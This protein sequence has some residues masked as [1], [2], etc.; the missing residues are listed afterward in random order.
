MTTE[1]GI[2]VATGVAANLYASND[3]G[4]VNF[5]EQIYSTVKGLVQDTVRIGLPTFAQ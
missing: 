4:N 3:A 2:L 1:A 5:E